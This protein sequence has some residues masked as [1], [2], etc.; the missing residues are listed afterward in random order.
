[1]AKPY[2]EDLRRRV[3]GAIEGGSHHPGSCGAMRRQHQLGRPLPQASPG[4]GQR[5][6]RPNSA[7]TR[8]S[9]WRR[10]RIW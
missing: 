6:A 7:A 9:R 2:S 5:R 3:V 10:T 4:D 8:I 1:M